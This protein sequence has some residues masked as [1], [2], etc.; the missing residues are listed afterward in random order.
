M[1]TL[2]ICLVLTGTVFSQAPFNSNER[3]VKFDNQPS[4]IQQNFPPIPPSPRALPS[5]SSNIRPGQIQPGC[6]P[7]RSPNSN[8]LWMV[9]L[10][11]FLISNVSKPE[12][13]NI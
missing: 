6:A 11:D 2:L 5:P 7:Y 12:C 10:N 9:Q 8:G 13:T 3:Q 1:K 4:S